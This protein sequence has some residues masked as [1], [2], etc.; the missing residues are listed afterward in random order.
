MAA[1]KKACKAGKVRRKIKGGRKMC[2]PKKKAAGPKRAAP[3][4]RRRL[5]GS[6]SPEVRREREATHAE[7]R[8]LLGPGLYRSLNAAAN[9]G[10]CS[11]SL[12]AKRLWSMAKTDAA[13]KSLAPVLSTY[14]RWCQE[15]ID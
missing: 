13:R 9:R 6:V 7:Q 8:R 10:P 5:V 3:K 11:V 1:K 12:S 2:L 15:S 14:I 4:R